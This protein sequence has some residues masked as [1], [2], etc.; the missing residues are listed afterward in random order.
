MS[1]GVGSGACDTS[2]TGAAS[3]GLYSDAGNW[4]AG[5]PNGNNGCITLPG[6]YTIH[7]QGA[8]P[9]ASSLTVGGSS[10][11]Q[12]LSLEST[13]SGSAALTTSS[14]MTIGSHGSV[15]LTNADGCAN[16]ATLAIPS[17]A[18]TNGGTIDVLAAAGGTRNIQG[19]IVNNGTIDLDSGVTLNVSGGGT[20]TNSGMVAATG[21]GQILMT[22]GTF[23]QGKGRLTGAEPVLLDDATL[24][25]TGPGK[26][27]I[28]EHGNGTLSG[29][30][31]AGQSLELESTCS[32]PAALSDAT[33]LKN[34]GTI[35]LTNG[36]AAPTMFRWR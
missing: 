31:A 21:S 13:C 28:T 1:A 35:T 9:V 33:N 22:S 8:P 19:S 14:S 24:A 7:L 20:F 25:Y 12:T 34:S 16:D 15:L 29:N 10:G 5:V 23:T 6:T 4:T 2:W 27:L 17:G 30:L 3:D 26:G 36:T 32:E 11:T 18:L